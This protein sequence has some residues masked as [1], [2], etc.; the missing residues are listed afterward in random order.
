MIEEHVVVTIGV[1]L[2]PAHAIEVDDRRAMDPAKD[3]RVQFLIE[4]REA[5]AQKMGFST[6]M[7]ARIVV[8]GFD[9]IDVGRFDEGNS[10]GALDSEAIHFAGLLQV[11]RD[12]FLGAVK[13]SLEA[14]V[15]ERLQQVVERARFK[16]SQGI[17]IV[18]ALL[19]LAKSKRT[20]SAVYQKESAAATK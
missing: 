3:R 14:G 17:L 7:E 6:H 20:L 8:G 12:S 15:I 9:P 19:P 1:Q 10:P 5:A 16:S 4:I 18:S 13:G 11:G 2:E